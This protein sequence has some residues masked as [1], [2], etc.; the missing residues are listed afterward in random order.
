MTELLWLRRRAQTCTSLEPA[1]GREGASAALVTARSDLPTPSALSDRRAYRP[2]GK[3]RLR[4][5]GGEEH[6]LGTPVVCLSGPAKGKLLIGEGD[7]R[8]HG[9]PRRCLPLR[10]P[11]RHRS[12][13]WCPPARSAVLGQ[14]ER[15]AG[16]SPL[17]TSRLDE[18]GLCVHGV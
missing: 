17:S 10:A 11:I 9:C 7:D 12:V 15:L 3:T 5:D 18:R 1:V 6:G 13:S 14:S 2:M 16:P 8:S 4:V